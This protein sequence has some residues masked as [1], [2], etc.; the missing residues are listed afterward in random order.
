M[1]TN[2]ICRCGRRLKLKRI[3]S[4]HRG[5][6]PACGE[7]IE[8]PEAAPPA[9]EDE[10]N[11]QG[12]YGVEEQVSLEV[13][14]A[15]EKEWHWEG[16]YEVAEIRKPP[17]AVRA[18]APPADEP[19]PVEPEPWFPPPLLFPTRGMEGLAITVAVGSMLWLMA[20]L[21]PEYCLALIADADGLG[22]LPMGYLVSLV[23]SMPVLFFS[24]LVATYWFQYLGRVLVSASEGG[25]FPPRLPDRNVDGLT[26]GMASWAIWIVLGLSV[27]SLPA[28]IGHASRPG[29]IGLAVGLGLL[30]LPYALMALLLTF[31]HEDDLAA[32]PWR[33]AANLRR[34]GPSFL[35][36]SGSTAFTLGAAALAFAGIFQLRVGH[37]AWYIAGSLGCWLLLVW[38]T[39]VAMHTLGSYFYARRDRL[40]W[41]RPRPWW[42]GQ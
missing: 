15:P 13:E 31:L 7:M 17:I 6:C 21:V 4:D 26:G 30:G 37:F 41:R 23:T 19:E 24:P 33:V 2:V 20:T 28:A 11:W 1:T 36:L 18:P 29:D 27:G 12:T 40:K 35:I 38:M 3:P 32:S 25:R 5:R 16:A 42:E 10:W 14:P 22:A 39:L 9:V 8:I 34:V